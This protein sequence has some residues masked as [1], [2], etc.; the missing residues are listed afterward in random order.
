MLSGQEIWKCTMINLNSI[1]P[2]L[3]PILSDMPEI[4]NQNKSLEEMQQTFEEYEL[5]EIPMAEGVSVADRKLSALA[6]GEDLLVRIYQPSQREVGEQLPALLWIHGGGFIGG[7]VYKDDALCGSFVSEGNCVVVSVDYRLAPQYLFPQGFNDCYTALEW[8]VSEGVRELSLDVERITVGGC[9]A[10]GCLAAGVVLRARDCEGP[11]ICYQLL[12]IPA[13]DDRHETPSARAVTDARVWNRTISTR[14]WTKYLSEVDGEI[15]IYAAPGRAKDLS[16]LPPT[17][18]SV[19]EQDLLRDEGIQYAQRLSQSGV[20][21]ELHVYPGTYHGSVLTGPEAEVTRCH[22][23]DVR[24]S[25][26]TRFWR[27]R[28]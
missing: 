26:K 24:A 12:M 13:L 23:R 20:Q 22:L 27:E 6:N 25:L 5:P 11:K 21:T 1:D 8:L 28:E 10:G 14:I 16:G 19:E 4:S 17:F 2:E 3:R 7:S 15:P 18:V 9:S